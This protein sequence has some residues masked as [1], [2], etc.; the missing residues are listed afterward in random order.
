MIKSNLFKIIQNNVIRGN[1]Y[2]S[3]KSHEFLLNK[4][5]N[6]NK[7]LSFTNCKTKKNESISFSNLVL[8][9]DYYTLYESDHKASM[10]HAIKNG[11]N[12]IKSSNNSPV[13]S[14]VLN[15]GDNIIDRDELIIL[16]KSNISIRN[17]KDLLEA[18][19]KDM[20]INEIQ[21]SLEKLGV[22]KLDCYLLNLDKL[23][24]GDSVNSI[25]SAIVDVFKHLDELVG[26]GLIKSYGISSKWLLDPKVLSIETLVQC[27]EKNMSSLNFQFVEYPFNAYQHQALTM[28]V[29]GREGTMNLMDYCKDCKLFTVNSSPSLFEI[30]GDIKLKEEKKRLNRFMMVNY[31][32]DKDLPKVLKE[33]FDLCIHLETI[34]PI[35]KDTIQKELVNRNPDIIG[36]LQWGHNLVYS[37]HNPKLTNLWTWKHILSTK[38]IPTLHDAIVSIFGNHIMNSWGG[39]YKKATS[40]LFDYYTRSLESEIYQRQLLYS[41]LIDYQNLFEK[42]KIHSTSTATSSKPHHLSLWQKSI[43]LS[44]LGADMVSEYPVTQ[45]QVDSLISEIE[46]KS[47]ALPTI[48]YFSH[49]E[50]KINKNILCDDK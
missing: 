38:I 25:Y 39:G 4:K 43:M 10:I 47:M 36:S 5:E 32:A 19:E 7:N 22:Q 24:N 20:F 8:N 2:Y 15:G 31:N 1:R 42:F 21:R 28:R 29:Y 26:D 46:F 6:V 3:L 12:V 35:F 18:I 17:S 44:S 30:S 9:T 33:A 37:Q 40:Q 16:K 23:E 50:S 48:H 27:I 13:I 49:L 14:S 34:N 41:D 45:S 11:C